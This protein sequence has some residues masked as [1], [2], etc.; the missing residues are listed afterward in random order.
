MLLRYPFVLLKKAF[1]NLYFLMFLNGFLLA[2]LFY[3]RMQSSYEN[4]LF[5]S[6]K[7]SIDK[8]ID[9]NDTRDSIAIKAMNACHYLMSNRAN[10]FSD[11]SPLATETELFRSA[12][13]DL[14]T[15][16]GACGSYALVL[17]RL[18]DTYGYPVRIAQMK[19]GGVF[20]AHNI[21]EV[22]AGLSWIVL[23]PTFNVSFIRPDGRLASFADVRQNWNFYVHQ[24][25]KDYKLSYR[26][27]D[28]RYTNWGKIPVLLP[29]IKGLL[30]L[31]LGPRKTNVISLRT[32]FLKIY[33]TCFYGILLFYLPV[34]LL[35]FRRLILV[36][37]FPSQDIPFTINNLVK[38][39]RLHFRDSP[40]R[41]ALGARP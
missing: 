27:E 33:N 12:S 31:T 29:A 10:I 13:E 22:K 4:S 1:S 19:A 23:D 2:S 39:L 36:K 9:P 37:V 5:A 40:L 32:W 3:F 15:T 6:V 38:Y 14:M 26:Y 17:A 16:R 34:V 25:P 28:V 20:A 30:N 35:T 24:V 11:A 8:T 41:R 7:A 21:V 18:L